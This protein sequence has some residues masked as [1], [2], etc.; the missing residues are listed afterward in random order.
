MCIG[1]EGE[2][3]R[4]KC[5]GGKRDYEEKDSLGEEER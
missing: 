1:K 5:L 3:E 4:L 2:G